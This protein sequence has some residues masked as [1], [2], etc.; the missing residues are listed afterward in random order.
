MQI[1]VK[2]VQKQY[3]EEFADKH[4]LVL[5]VNERERNDTQEEAIKSYMKSISNKLLILHAFSDDRKERW[6]PILSSTYK[7]KHD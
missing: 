3:L 6:I 5:E 7:V 1:D 4:K 2:L